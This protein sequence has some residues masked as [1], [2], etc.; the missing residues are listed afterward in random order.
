[1]NILFHD[2]QLCLRGTTVALYDYAR[3]NEEI[4]GNKSYVVFDRNSRFND[5]PAI[6]KF[7]KKFPERVI[8][9]N[10]FTEVNYINDKFDIDLFYIIKSGEMDGK[11]SNRKNCVHAVFQS[12]QPHGNVYAY[13]SEWLS[14]KMTNGKSPYVPHIVSLPEPNKNLR[15]ILQVPEDAFLFGRYGGKDQFDIPFVKEAILEFVQSK[16]DA[17]FVFFNTEPFC[18]H[19]QVKFYDYIVDLQDKANFIN[20]CDAMIHGRSMGESF[21]LAICEFLYGN[22]PVLASE[23]G[24]DLHHTW[25]VDKEFLYKDKQDLLSKMNHV[26]KRGIDIDFKNSVEKFNPTTVMKKFKEVFL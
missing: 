10:S 25:I 5:I 14:E 24:H 8:A 20:S 26:Y 6:E 15:S 2:N 17:Y 16:K 13:V 11:L 7:T 4:L 1:M 3:Y 18:N 9:Y 12:Y 21:G 19:N 22:K 23:G